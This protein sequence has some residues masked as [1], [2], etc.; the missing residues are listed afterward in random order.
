[1][2]PQS[3]RRATDFLGFMARLRCRMIRSGC[4]TYRDGNRPEC[5]YL[6]DPG[7]PIA[8][9]G[10]FAQNEVEMAHA[11]QERKTFSHRSF[12]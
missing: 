8:V 10:D 6:G 5:N 7:E 12:E 4:K 1:M 9:R 2:I 11:E 3:N